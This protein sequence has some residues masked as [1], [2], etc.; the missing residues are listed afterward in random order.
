MLEC[1][2]TREAAPK[3]QSCTTQHGQTRNFPVETHRLVE[4]CVAFAGGKLKR[5]ESEKRLWRET[6]NTDRAFRVPEFVSGRLH[7]TP[8]STGV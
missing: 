8:I 1:P 4:V 5:E 2:D 7:I 6:S 3:V